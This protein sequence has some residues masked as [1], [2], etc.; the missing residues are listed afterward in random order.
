MPVKVESRDHNESVAGGETLV[1]RGEYFEVLR[2]GALEVL[3]AQDG[4]RLALFAAGTWL[5]AQVVD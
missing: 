2:H 1:E 5:S 3:D 4:R